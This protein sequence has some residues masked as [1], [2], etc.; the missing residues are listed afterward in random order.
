[1]VSLSCWAPETP[2]QPM[3][4]ARSLLAFTLI[5][6]G[7]AAATVVVYRVLKEL[8]MHRYAAILILAMLVAGAA[9]LAQDT[10]TG[11]YKVLK[12]ARVGGE[13]NWDY[14]YADVAG[15]RLYI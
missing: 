13:G 3:R 9:V 4:A 11:P 5:A 7:A 14:I 2:T 15:R 10:S 8:H 6:A 12:T 1:M